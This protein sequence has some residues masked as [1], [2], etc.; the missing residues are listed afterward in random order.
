MLCLGFSFNARGIR[1]CMHFKLLSSTKLAPQ[2]QTNRMVDF[3]MVSTD[4]VGTG[5]EK[6]AE[7]LPK[8]I[9]I[10]VAKSLCEPALPLPPTSDCVMCAAKDEGCIN[11]VVPT[12][13]D[14]IFGS[15]TTVLEDYI[16]SNRLRVDFGIY[17]DRYLAV[18]TEEK[19]KMI[20]SIIDTV[21]RS[22]GR[23][24]QADSSSGLL[25]EI[26]EE[27]QIQERVSEALCETIRDKDMK[28]GSPPKAAEAAKAKEKHSSKPTADPATVARLL[29]MQ[30]E[31]REQMEKESNITDN[32]GDDDDDYSSEGN[33]DGQ[34]K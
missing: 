33:D 22:G 28:Q 4:H 3:L 16:G 13:Y 8:E 32:D 23:F 12:N 25:N 10:K 17:S 5:G 9:M 29:M 24:L 31:I 1:G 34:E 26:H 21:R 19:E 7:G 11:H 20:Q 2:R 30:M 18:G 15:G 14:I 27:R 6:N